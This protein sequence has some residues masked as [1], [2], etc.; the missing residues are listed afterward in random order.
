MT[1]F[2]L[3]PCAPSLKRMIPVV[4]LATFILV[5]LMFEDGA[6]QASSKPSPIRFG[7]S[8]RVE[9]QATGEIFVEPHLAVDPGNAAHLV[10]IGEMSMVAVS[11]T[12]TRPCPDRLAP[13]FVSVFGIP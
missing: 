7:R 12:G 9:P 4:A 10:A 6:G 5:S 2:C 1:W 3:N 8:T 13:S 11:S